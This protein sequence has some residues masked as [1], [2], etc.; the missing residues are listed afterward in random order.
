MCRCSTHEG[1]CATSGAAFTPRP[2]EEGGEGR[3]RAALTLFESSR[4]SFS[5]LAS[6]TPVRPKSPILRQEQV[7]FLERDPGA[8]QPTAGERVGGVH[9]GTLS[10]RTLARNGV[11]PET[12]WLRMPGVTT[13]GEM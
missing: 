1:D 12:G 6:T 7:R 2:G 9:S 10:R 8:R 4:Q 11:A 5:D 3:A 13:R